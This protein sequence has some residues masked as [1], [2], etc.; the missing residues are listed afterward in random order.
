MRRTTAGDDTVHRALKTT[1][2]IDVRELISTDAAR[3][4]GSIA[5]R[6]ASGS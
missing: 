4:R 5:R 6:A 3:Q 2:W 1:V